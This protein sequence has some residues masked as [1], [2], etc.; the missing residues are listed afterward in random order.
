MKMQIESKL[1]H[2][3]FLYTHRSVYIY[4]YIY[5]YKLDEIWFALHLAYKGLNAGR[6]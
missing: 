5:V 6:D 3:Q 2:I 4:I 1:L